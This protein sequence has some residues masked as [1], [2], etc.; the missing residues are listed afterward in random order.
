M[1]DSKELNASRMVYKLINEQSK[2]IDEL[3]KKVDKLEEINANIVSLEALI[4]S[5]VNSETYQ[6]IIALELEKRVK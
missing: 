4:L 5:I 6:K 1:S 3:N 2:K